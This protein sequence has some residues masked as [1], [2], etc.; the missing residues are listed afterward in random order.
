MKG[1][2]IK[3]LRLR[4]GLTQ[5]ELAAEI[6]V[7]RVTVAKWE[8]RRENP[9]CRLSNE[10]WPTWM[11]GAAECRLGPVKAINCSNIYTIATFGW[12]HK[13]Y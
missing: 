1:E 13:Q 5:T 12:N 8:D 2:E 11:L 4:L 3:A 7:H 9:P 10:P 6:G